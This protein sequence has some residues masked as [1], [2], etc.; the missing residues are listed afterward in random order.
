MLIGYRYIVESHI[1]QLCS[2]MTRGRVFDGDPHAQRFQK[3]NLS[4]FIY[5]L[6]HKFFSSIIGTIEPLY[7]KL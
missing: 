2:G 6:F 1:I 3:F 5:R 4:A 7:C